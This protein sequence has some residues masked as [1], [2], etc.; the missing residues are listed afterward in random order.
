MTIGHVLVQACRK[1]RPYQ[2]IRDMVRRSFGTLNA[3]TKQYKTGVRESTSLSLKPR[4]RRSFVC[5]LRLQLRRQQP[6]E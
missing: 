4:F 6:V 2:L 5:R 1:I 3:Q